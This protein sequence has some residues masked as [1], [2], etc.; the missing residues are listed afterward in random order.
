MTV[1]LYLDAADPTM[2]FVY[3]Q[4][5][6]GAVFGGDRLTTRIAV[7]P[8]GHVHLTTPSA[9]KIMRMEGSEAKQT[10]E[11]DVGTGA[12][13][14]YLPELLIPQAGSRYE[15]DIVVTLGDGASFIGVESVAPGR[16]ASGEAFAYERLRLSL[17]VRTG[18]RDICVDTLD[19]EPARR[20]PASHGL[21]GQ[22]RYVGSIVAAARG[23][24]GGLVTALD[25]AMSPIPNVLAAAGDL[26]SDAGAY[27]RVLA[28]SP[29]DLR[30]A[31][32]AGW[33]AAR[34]LLTG[35][36]AAKRRK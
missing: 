36:P 33:E 21:L 2:A 3:V 29:G 26:P 15:Q 17:V 32:H 14:E 16:L 19:L 28:F 22:Y 11:V 30:R 23:H 7:D 34:L 35:H 27:A 9:T 5:P 18:Q 25:E 8:G 10:L 6:T 20:S 24:P 4:N 1:P 13:V 31:L 12:Y